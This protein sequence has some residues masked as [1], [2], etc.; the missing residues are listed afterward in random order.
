MFEVVGSQTGRWPK[1]I[2]I[3]KLT[4]SDIGKGVVYKT[5]PDYEPQQGYIT[6]FNKSYIFVAFGTRTMGRGEACDPSDL[7]W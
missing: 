4:E 2:D 1:G 5:A 3:T 7:E 6:S